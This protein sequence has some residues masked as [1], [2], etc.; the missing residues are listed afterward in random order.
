[1]A[2]GILTPCNMAWSW[3][4]FHQVTLQCGMWLWNHDIEFPRWQHPAVWQAALGWHAIEFARTSAILEFYIWFW[5][6][7]VDMSLCTSLQN[8]IQIGPPSAEENDV[9]SIF[10]M[11]HFRGS[12]MGSLKCPCTT[13]YRSSLSIETIA[14]NCLV[15]EKIVFLHWVTTC[16]ENLEMSWNLT[17]VR[18]MSGILLKIK[19]LS[20]KKSC[21]GKVA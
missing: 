11:A 14:L 15:F 6:W 18:E 1:M 16:L 19:E 4:R 17:A 8:F 2:N 9:M 10:R 20:G 5:F 13:S 3:H 12:I 21:H 7:P